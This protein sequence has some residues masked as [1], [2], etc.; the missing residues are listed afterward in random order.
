MEVLEGAPSTSA[1]GQDGQEDKIEEEGRDEEV[2]N[3]GGETALLPVFSDTEESEV[4]IMTPRQGGVGP[5]RMS[6]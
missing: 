3:H 6:I 1:Q 5:R 4:V 2:G